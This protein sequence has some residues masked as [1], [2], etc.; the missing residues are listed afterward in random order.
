MSLELALVVNVILTVCP[1][2]YILP[3]VA[4]S[5][6]ALIAVD[7]VPVWLKSLPSGC[8][9]RLH[10]LNEA[11]TLTVT[12]A[13]ADVPPPVQVSVYVL[14]VLIGPVLVPVLL[15]GW[16]PL[17]APLA[18]QE[19]AFVVVHASVLAPPLLTVAGLAVKEVIVTG[20]VVTWP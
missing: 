7:P 5:T 19:S 17:Q 4:L 16:L 18:V 20:G 15:V 13:V 8:I 1:G 6:S 2:E 3:E 11:F 12:L 14:V 10:G 9:Y